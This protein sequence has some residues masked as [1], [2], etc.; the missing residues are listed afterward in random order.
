MGLH[1][2][3]D[4]AMIEIINS[5]G[6]IKAITISDPHFCSAT[7]TLGRTFNCRLLVRKADKRRRAQR[8]Y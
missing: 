8:Q 5:F 7:V 2:L 4:D 1:Q 6:G 3:L